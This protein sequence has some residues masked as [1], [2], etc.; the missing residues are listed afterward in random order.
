LGGDG[1]LLLAPPGVR[2]GRAERSQGRGGVV[3]SGRLVFQVAW[4]VRAWG[5]GETPRERNGRWRGA[6]VARRRR[7]VGGRRGAIESCST[8]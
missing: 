6:R 7:V 8:W 3:E 1:L 4:T 2:L 5:E